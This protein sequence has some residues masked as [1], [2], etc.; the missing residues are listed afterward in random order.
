MRNP[1]TLIARLTRGWG[2]RCVIAACALALAES[3]ALADPTRHLEMF[4][5][6]ARIQSSSGVSRDLRQPDRLPNP[7]ITG[8]GSWDPRRSFGTVIFDESEN[9]YK[10]WY[11][12]NA[13]GNSIAYATSVDGLDWDYPSAGLVSFPKGAAPTPANTN[14][15]MLFRGLGHTSLYN[16]SVVKDDADP[17][18]MRRYKIVYLDS[19]TSGLTGTGGAFTGTSPDG[20]HW[21]RTTTPAAPQLVIRTSEQSV[22]DVLELMYDSQKQKYVIYSKGY[23]R[24]GN[25]NDHRQIVRTESSDFVNWSTPQVVLRHD[26]TLQDPQSY[27]ASVFEYQG[28]YVMPLRIYHN[29]GL[30]D[31]Q[32]GDRSIDVQ[33][34]ASRDGI[35]WTRV[36]NKGTF[37]ERGAD[38]T[39]D[40]GMILPYRPFE[41][42]G[43]IQ[44]YYHGWNGVHENPDGTPVS[45]VATVGLATLDAGRFVG[46]SVAGAGTATL[47]TKTFVM[48]GDQLFLNA[49]LGDEGAIRVALLQNG[50][51][52][53]P[54]Y[55]DNLA[56]LTRYNDLYYAVSFPGGDL[57][58]LAGMNLGLRFFIEGDAMLYGYT[59]ALAVVPEPASAGLLV[60]AIAGLAMRRRARGCGGSVS[61]NG[62]AL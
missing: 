61:M 21:T 25:R 58:S 49:D 39:W 36:A 22:H 2:H 31:G 15:N 43:Q 48:D 24:T 55:S 20:I 41:K 13:Q 27:G 9:L 38:G 17:D 10:A 29:T 50:T 45:R 19:T 57:S 12:I 44:I 8:G 52:V 46:M 60:V 18:P 3:A 62:V 35:N 1:V 37:M 51:T 23:E 5:D 30:A 56:E 4:L 33:L 11:Q 34:A 54:G 28:M 14:N 26:N 53:L 42:D 16:S 40:D 47:T 32:Q 6:D 59:T 7:V